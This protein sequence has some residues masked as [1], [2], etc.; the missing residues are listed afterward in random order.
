MLRGDYTDESPLIQVHFKSDFLSEEK[1]RPL[2]SKDSLQDVCFSET[3]TPMKSSF[4]ASRSF[5]SAGSKVRVKRLQENVSVYLREVVGALDK[6]E[7][8]SLQVEEEKA[9]TWNMMHRVLEE[10]VRDS[11]MLIEHYR[12]TI[13]A[14]HDDFK[15]QEIS[16]MKVVGSGETP[17]SAFIELC[18]SKLEKSAEKFKQT[19][20]S[21]PS[22][23]LDVKVINARLL[24][25]LKHQSRSLEED[26]S[27]LRTQMNQLQ[28]EIRRLT[29][30]M[31][32]S[33]AAEQN[34]MRLQAE[35][36]DLRGKASLS[37]ASDSGD[38]SALDDYV[39]CK[40]AEILQVMTD[41]QS[42]VKSES[43][44]A[45]KSSLFGGES[46]A[47]KLS[48]IREDERFVGLRTPEALT[49]LK[50]AVNSALT[51]A[52]AKL[53]FKEA[54]T[55]KAMHS[56]KKS[57][58]SEMRAYS[59]KTEERLMELKGQI[60]KEEAAKLHSELAALANSNETYR[61]T[62]ERLKSTVNDLKD[63]LNAET[64]EVAQLLAENESLVSL[65]EAEVREAL[66]CQEAEFEARLKQLKEDVQIDM[67]EANERL[68][69]EYEETFGHQKH[70]F[71]L[72][73]DELTDQ[74][75]DYR[76]MQTEFEALKEDFEGQ[77]EK[78]ALELEQA[79]AMKVDHVKRIY[80]DKYDELFR[81][82]SAQIA[83]LERQL[84][85]SATQRGV[86][87][88]VATAK[89]AREMELLHHNLM[90]RQ[91]TLHDKEV[92]L[93]KAEFDEFVTKAQ[94]EIAR[95]ARL[96]EQ[97]IG[98]YGQNAVLRGVYGDLELLSRHLSQKLMDSRR[99]VR[100]LGE[101]GRH[102]A[103]VQCELVHGGGFDYRVCR[104]CG[105]NDTEAESCKFHP[106][107]TKVGAADFIYGPEWH[108][109]REDGHQAGSSGCFVYPKHYY[110]QRKVVNK[111]EPLTLLQDSKEPRESRGLKDSFTLKPKLSSSNRLFE[112]FE[113]T[114]KERIKA[115]MKDL[116]HRSRSNSPINSLSPRP[117]F[118]DDEL[119]GALSPKPTEAPRFTK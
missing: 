3:V 116:K 23:R 45:L 27:L 89:V 64:D 34:C 91:K 28:D 71:Q 84:K 13:S 75:K 25:Q 43:W 110:I 39:A 2:D 11:L 63:K 87:S 109:C 114:E 119:M 61:D 4:T 18:Q 113:G 106:F 118:E 12:L 1:A 29:K 99:E 111:P 44:R 52:E 72:Q 50:E 81:I 77:K 69:Q 56:L 48:D 80:T 104:R 53:K 62:I 6:C 112:S 30:H 86:Q 107:L 8:L 21:C 47:F 70:L 59:E 94:L 78:V 42:S 7:D 97:T 67:A 5:D 117:I 74:I 66:S 17:S 38:T 20:E 57:S 22:P 65:K 105:K 83:D 100:S 103:E 90:E 15:T 51:Q 85:S 55:D 68:R 41:F 79:W 82:T 96:V 93:L 37:A 60:R 108:R 31:G 14:L 33:Q 36:N 24:E 101:G 73:I 88:E 95:L 115:A 76:S 58:I 26:N 10:A 46:Q 32:D 40:V 35:L 98:N 102:D 9:N 54:L 92:D 49:R 16:L 19:L